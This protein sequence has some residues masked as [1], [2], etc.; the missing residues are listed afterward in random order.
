MS[1][2]S[3][4]PM[5]E[6][7]RLMSGLLPVA[8]CFA[9]ARPHLLIPA[10]VC[11]L[12][13]AARVADPVSP[14]RSLTLAVCAWSLALVA[15]HLVNLV[16]DRDGDRRN[17]KN[18]FWQGRV[19][20]RCLGVAAGVGAVAALLCGYHG[21]VTAFAA[22]AATLALGALYSLPPVRMA[23][24]WGW[25][26]AANTGGY[27]LIAPL[28]GFVQAGGL[29]GETVNAGLPGL[30]A[31]L[32]LLHML[33]GAAFLWTTLLDLDGDQRSGKISMAV[34][35]GPAV[36][37][38]LALLLVVLALGVAVFA[39]HTSGSLAGLPAAWLG[40]LLLCCVAVGIWC[41]TESRSPVGSQAAA[42]SRPPTPPRRLLIAGITL[43][44]VAAALPGLQ[45]WPLFALPIAAWV[46]ASYATRLWLPRSSESPGSPGSSGSPRRAP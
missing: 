2:F 37:T 32:V 23:H 20:G 39:P 26:L 46:A 45:R 22:V 18:L 41:A 5:R 25:D 31:T 36:T 15:T 27:A 10:W 33:V 12:S 14:S 19:S 8:V 17:A 44:I 13:G 43:A 28:F 9:A 3:P 30:A 7:S 40:C 29:G 1:G 24:R 38:R 42:G 21:G 16:A 11:A 4:V 34:R 6:G 35:W